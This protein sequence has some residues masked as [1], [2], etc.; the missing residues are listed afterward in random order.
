MSDSSQQKRRQ[1]MLAGRSRLS[2]IRLIYF[3]EMRDQLR[4]RRTLFTIAILPMLLYPLVGML[5]LQIAQFTR[6]HTISVCVVGL[7]HVN[8]QSIE[9]KNQSGVEPLLVQVRRD[10]ENDSQTTPSDGGTEKYE[11]TR[12]LWESGSTIDVFAYR[13]EDLAQS[14]DLDDQA[15]R[16]VRDQVFD[17]VVCVT[18]PLR[19]DVEV[20]AT[21]GPA[22]GLFY[23]IASDQ[24]MVAKDRVTGILNRWRGT[25]VRSRLADAG[26]ELSLLDPFKINDVDIAPE[27]TREAAFW[28]KLLPFIMLVWAMT[29]AFYPAIDLVA[30]EKERGTLETLLCSPAL[31]GEIVWGKLGAVMSFSMMTAI[32]NASSMLV[33][34]SFVFNQIGIGPDGG[35]MGSPPLVPMLWLLVALVPL[36]ALFSALALAVAAMARSSKEGQYYLMPLMMVTLPL[37]LLPMLPGTNLNL[38]TSLIPVTGM[39][40]LVRSLVEGHHFEALTYLPTVALVTA[41]CLFAATRWAKRQFESE[42]V[43]FGDGDQWEL[44]AW[45]RHLWRD[46]QRAAT[47]ALAL[48]CGTIILVALFFGKLAVTEMPTTFSGIAMLIYVPQIGFILAPTLLMATMMT[49]SLKSSLRMTGCSWRTWSLV[50]LLSVMLHPLY[51]QVAS[52]VSYMYPISPQALEQMRPFG[53]QVASAPWLSVILLMAAL[54]A[55]CEELAF[56]GF[57]FGGLLR[58]QSPVRAVVVTAFMFGISH[59]VLQQSISASIMGVLLGWVALRTGSVLPGIMIHFGNN[60]LSVSLGRIVDLDLPV[61]N[62]FLRVDA[63]S[64]APEYHWI[65]TACGVGVSLACLIGIHRTTQ[66]HDAIESNDALADRIV[67]GHLVKDPSLKRLVTG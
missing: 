38:G 55:V 15:R 20:G 14:A 32:L 11:F 51:L 24:S 66:V 28:S 31:R 34:S 56:R 33:T 64:G 21:T 10:S 27:R 41:G 9:L 22:V 63:I 4:D 37:V 59:G 47:P 52:L 30:G 44:G 6:Q 3:R 1:A 54:P 8:D 48:G 26:V 23:N 7:E 53:E 16:W 40:L 57:I 45:M 12:S 62:D 65:W 13:A 42:A 25:W 49:T 61:V 35:S 19:Q 2:A 58:N 18:A 67:S 43:L 50:G 60:A 5:L 46:R 17:C 39:F 36:S 29:G